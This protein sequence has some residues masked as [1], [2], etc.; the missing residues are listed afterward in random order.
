[1]LRPRRSVGADGRLSAGILV[2]VSVETPCRN[3][4]LCSHFYAIM[5][6]FLPST[7]LVTGGG[8][9]AQGFLTGIGCTVA[10]EAAGVELLVQDDERA[11]DDR[12]MRIARVGPT[13]NA[14]SAYRTPPSL[15]EDCVM[16]AN[17]L[18]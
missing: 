9:F 11:G 6:I 2:E 5:T 16:N 8:Q 10:L 15:M 14:A 1:M 7:L 13:L 4:P 17:A 3:K 12:V 18:R